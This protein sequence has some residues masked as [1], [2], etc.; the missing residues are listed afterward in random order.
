MYL[1]VPVSSRQAGKTM[2]ELQDCLSEYTKQEYLD[3]Q[4]K[5]YCEKC[6]KHQPALKKIDIWKLPSILIVCIKRFKF[7]SRGR[8]AKMD[9]YIDFPMNN[10]DLSSHVSSPQREKPMYDLFA[11]ANHQG[12]INQGHYFAYCWN[13]ASKNWYYYNDQEIKLIK[14]L[15]KIISPDAY[16]LFYAKT[17]TENY[18]RQTLSMPDYWPHVIAAAL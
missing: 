5:W 4:N 7:L 14:N 6:K 12:S 2:I 8:Y 10:L 13:H 15:S 11:V 16:I 3:G 17:S 1:S 18:L 9:D